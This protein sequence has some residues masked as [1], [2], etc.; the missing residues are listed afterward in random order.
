MFSFVFFSF[1]FLFFCYEHLIAAETIKKCK[2][3]TVL[4]CND[5]IN[6]EI[7]LIIYYCNQ[8]VCICVHGYFLKDSP[9]TV[10]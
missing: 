10:T 3:F 8:T 4:L 6:T 9:W 7:N 1:V 2:H 5:Q